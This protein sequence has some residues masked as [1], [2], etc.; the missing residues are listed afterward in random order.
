MFKIANTPDDLGRFIAGAG[1]RQD[2]V[3]VSLRQRRSVPGKFLLALLVRSQDRLIGFRSV[4]F[5]PRKKCG[6][7]V[8]ADAGVVV[9]DLPDISVFIKNAGSA[10]GSVALRRDAL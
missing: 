3:V 8:I 7:K 5:Q 10:I 1:Q 9:Y 2:H 6:A 4:I